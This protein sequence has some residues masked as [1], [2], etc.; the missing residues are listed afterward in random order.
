MSQTYLSAVGQA[1]DPLETAK[2]ALPRDLAQAADA[3]GWGRFMR[4]RYSVLEL[5]KRIGEHL[6]DSLF[7]AELHAAADKSEFFNPK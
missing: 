2:A 1:A 3:A 5:V 4:D 6:S 7:L